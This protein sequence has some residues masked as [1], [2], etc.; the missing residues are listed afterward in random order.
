MLNSIARPNLQPH[1]DTGLVVL[2]TVE[3]ERT[4]P[5]SLRV[6]VILPSYNESV[7]IGP[8]VSAFQDALPDATIYVFD[9]NSTDNTAQVAREAGAVVGFEAS[10]GKGSVV[11]R[12]LAD[13]DAD[14][15]VMADGDATYDAAS[16]PALIERLVSGNFDMITGNRSSTEQAAYRP[17]HRFGNRVLTGLVEWLFKCKVGDLLSGYRVFSRRFAKTFPAH[18]RG[19]DIETELTVFALQLRLPID[20]MDTPYRAR[21]EGSNSKL[22]SVADGFRILRMIGLMLKEEKPMQFFSV[23]AACAFLPSLVVFASVFREFLETGLVERIPSLFTA[24]SGFVIA[25]LSFVCAVLLDT[26][27]RGRREARR[28]AYLSYP[29]P[30]NSS[31]STWSDVTETRS[32][33][34]Q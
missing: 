32:D 20:E 18:S 30:W 14:V 16:A 34:G 28:I 31:A 9:N 22:S 26:V 17:G 27:A 10:P 11:R 1:L 25:V 33:A 7:A 4:L 23:I 8:T 24:L 15:Y 3:P 12:M 6:A 29:P 19:F 2:K 21:M 13:I 5:A